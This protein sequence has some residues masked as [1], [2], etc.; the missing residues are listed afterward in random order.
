MQNLAGEKHQLIITK[1]FNSLVCEEMTVLDLMKYD[2]WWWI[3][4]RKEILAGVIL[5]QLNCRK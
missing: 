3:D 1:I 4:I 5:K 2:T